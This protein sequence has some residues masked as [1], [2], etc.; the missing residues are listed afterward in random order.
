MDELSSSAESIREKVSLSLVERNSTRFFRAE[1]VVFHHE[2]QEEVN[3]R[4]A[5]TSHQQV[6]H[7]LVGGL[8]NGTRD[9]RLTRIGEEHRFETPQIGRRD[10]LI[11]GL[12]LLLLA[13]G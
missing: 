5:E 13:L 3:Q 2:A 7:G 12:L 1:H 9:K 11:L 6:V 4:R 8:R 10:G